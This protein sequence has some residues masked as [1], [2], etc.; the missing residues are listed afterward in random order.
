MPR[1][2]RWCGLFLW[3]LF[4]A[5]G[6]PAEG[7]APIAFG[8]AACDHCQMVISDARYA[9]QIR[10]GGR[11]YRFDD[12][13]CAFAFL[14]ARPDGGAAAT[15][16]WVTDEDDLEWIDARSAFYRSGRRTPMAYGFGAI[17]SPEEG[18]IDYEAFRSALRARQRPVAP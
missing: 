15:E 14:E 1:V 16:L 4:L 2:R 17:A 8:R 11:V 5:C 13:G 12:P 6:D 9:A 18:A 3:A 7:P 10:L